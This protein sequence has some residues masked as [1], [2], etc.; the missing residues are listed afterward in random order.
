LLASGLGVIGFLLA[1]NLLLMGNFMQPGSIILI[2]VPILF[3]IA[4]KLGIDPIHFGVMITVNMQIGMITP[5]LVLN[6]HVA[7]GIGKLGL[8]EMRVAVWPWLLTMRI[9]L[10]IVTTWPPLST[11]SPRTLG[12]M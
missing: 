10:V 9:C 2:T 5:P 3:P 8:S 12:M 6:L 4:M 1:V 7:S 11:W